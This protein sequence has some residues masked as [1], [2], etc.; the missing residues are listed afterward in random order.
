V[1]RF[2][3]VHVHPPLAEFLEG[4][5]APFIDGLRAEFRSEI[6]AQTIDEIANHYRSLDG[7]A[8]LLAW[9]AER[10]TRRPAFTGARVAELVAQHP[11]VFVGFGSVDPL[12]GAA[13]VAGVHGAIRLG[14]KG[15]KFHPPAQRFS[16]ADRRVYP[17]WE[18]AESLR[19]PVLIHTG[20]TAM[21]AGMPG[22]G[23]IE[24][25]YGDPTL[26]DR[27]AVDFPNLQIVLAHPSWPWQEQAI[28]MAQHKA[29][30]HLE[31]SGWSPSRFPASLVEAIKGPLTHK[32]LFGTDYPFLTPERWIASFEKLGFTDEATQRILRDNASELLGLEG[33]VG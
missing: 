16:P 32:T 6:P 28:A 30:V 19:L 7:M 18:A 15:L 17:V 23:G 11:D 29:N 21:G 4:A 3:D 27:V 10:A 25:S 9:D 8:V 5:F 1:T 31:L 26:V 13:A 33:M 22:G 14:L 24:L 12:N 2:I 20:Y